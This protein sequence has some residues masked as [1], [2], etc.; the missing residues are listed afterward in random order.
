[1][2]NDGGNSGATGGIDR[3]PIAA[4][5]KPVFRRMAAALAASRISPNG[6]S[7]FGMACGLVGGAALAATAH[8]SSD[9]LERSAW[10]VGA[11]LVQVRLLCNLLDGLVAVE[12]GMRSATGDLYNDV[13]D[14][15]SDAATLIGL[16]YAAQSNVELGY[17]AALLAVFTAYCRVMG[18]SVAGVS[19]YRGPMAK[20][21]RMFLVTVTGLYLG[22]A[23]AAWRPT[24]G[25]NGAWGL[26]TVVLGVIAAGCAVTG[27]RRL[28]GAAAV[29]RGAWAGGGERR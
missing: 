6:I 17:L 2:G 1:M 28:R 26:P 10:L 9:G 19:D 12:G 8:A 4:R 18:K 13:P 29:L 27:M 23:P 11:A 21:Q 25:E 24:F 7:V 5:E 16:G 15:V 22:C 20:Q 14:R 3:R